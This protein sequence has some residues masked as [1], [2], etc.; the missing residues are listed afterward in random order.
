MPVNPI[1]EQDLQ[2]RLKLRVAVKLMLGVAALSVIYV[3]IAAIRSGSGEVP[4]VP[5]LRV[6][7]ADLLP[8]ESRLV[9][10]EGRPVLLY[11]RQDSDYA[12]LRTPD[13]RLIDAQSEK[14][15]QPAAFANEFRSAAPDLF[16]AIAL[17]TDLG[18]S[19]S[20]LQ[21]DSSNFQEKPW[22]GGFVD[23]CRKSRYDAAGRVYEAQYAD[24]NL[25][26]P[27]YTYSD[28]ILILGR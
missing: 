4:E 23:S 21:P 26:V 25:I 7:L 6:S 18:C 12:S 11:R 13:E 17:G 9:S 3:F 28:N 24:R 15:T 27:P 20:Y 10:W 1:S 2:R 22:D 8:G 5:T 16:V 14:S 19:V